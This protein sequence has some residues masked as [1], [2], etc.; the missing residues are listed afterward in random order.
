[1]KMTG[2]TAL[3][4]GASRGIGLAIA[5]M[6]A[7]HGV[8]LTLP[9]F[10][11]PESAA[12]MAEEFT[13]TRHLVLPVDLRSSDQVASLITAISDRFH[14]LDILINNIERGGMPILHG[15][16]HREVNRQQ[17]QLEQETTLHA[18]W[19]VF[20]LALPLLRQSREAIVVNISSIAGQI[21]RTGP[22]GLLFN[23]GYAAANRGLTLLTE[24]WAR[25]GAPNIRVNELMLGLIDSRHG[26][27][28]RGWELLTE[29]Q[30][31]ELL[32]HTLLGRTGTPEEVARA[33]LFLVRDADFLTGAVV[34]L[35]GGFV[36]GGELPPEMPE[37]AL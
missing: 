14:G 28:T 35:D 30:R 29:K 31:G 22:A 8:R 13:S 11:W 33:V 26:P 9:W 4:L 36:L 27:G 32:S 1:M 12:A 15:S 25:M 23:D 17:W 34:R 2:K 5:R 16:Y 6:L 24:T 7:D 20:E 21:G 10:D 19:L 3:V 18:K 37:G